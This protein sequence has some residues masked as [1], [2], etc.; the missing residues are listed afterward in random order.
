MNEFYKH[1][2]EA[3]K[4]KRFTQ[5]ELAEEANISRVMVSRYESGTVIPTV[6]VLVSLANALDVS[7]DYLLGRTDY[8]RSSDDKLS[9]QFPSCKCQDGFPKD[10]NELRKFVLDILKENIHFKF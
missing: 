1:L 8:V 2:R 6:D 4:A 10:K 5:E 3:R 7:T 9:N